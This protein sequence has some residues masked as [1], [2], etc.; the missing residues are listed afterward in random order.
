MWV[1]PFDD[2]RGKT[3]GDGQPLSPD[4]FTLTNFDLSRDGRKLAFVGWLPGAGRR[5]LWDVM[6]AT[7][8]AGSGYQTI[9]PEASSD[10]RALLMRWP[11]M[12][13]DAPRTLRILSASALEERVVAHAELMFPF[14]W[15]PDET[16]II[17]SAADGTREPWYV[18]AWPI[19]AAPHAENSVTVILR[20]PDLS[21][22]GA[23]YSP[24]GAWLCFNAH[25]TR[26][27][28]V[29]G[30]ATCQWAIRPAVVEGHRWKTVGR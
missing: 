13:R 28:S 27:N 14:D 26:G 3:Q 6:V 19:A 18:A 15:T 12:C 23:R 2:Q 25:G 24:D 11:L 20:D 30:V 22:W 8:K 16:A 17:G 9:S 10:T 1:I 5:Q 4:D 7:G 21:L 29:I